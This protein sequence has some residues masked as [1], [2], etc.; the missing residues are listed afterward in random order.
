MQLHAEEAV[1]AHL[2]NLQKEFFK[3]AKTNKNAP[4]IK[5]SDAETNSLIIAL[6]KL[7]KDGD[8]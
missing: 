7:L 1:T 6:E 4:F 8:K 2:E 5:L 3:Q